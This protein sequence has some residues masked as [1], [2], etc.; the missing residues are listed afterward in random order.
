MRESLKT[1]NEGDVLMM[2]TNTVNQVKELTTPIQPD[3][4]EP[5][6]KA[7][8]VFSALADLTVLCKSYGKVFY[9]GL[10]DFSKCHITGKGADLKVALVGER[11]TAIL[12]A[13][14]F[15]GKPCKVPI[16]VLECELVSEITGTRASCS[17]ERKGQSQYEISFQ[18]TIKGIH[19]LHIK[20]EGQHIRGSPLSVAVKMP[21]D[22]LGTH[23]LIIDRL[24]HPWGVAINQRGEVVVTEGD[25]HCVS[26]FSP[27]GEKIRS[28]GTRG[29][30]RG[31]FQNPHGVAVDGEGNIL[32]GIIVFRNSQ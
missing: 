5:N 15:E 7:D 28:F 29:S 4:L 13:I 18:P 25:G 32:A 24:E 12:R 11:S 9:P 19:Q 10:P 16:K 2:K 20:A 14:N 27:N 1:G 26:V 31:Q 21:V 22:K 8:V 17:V 30:G 23:I 6:T 3:M